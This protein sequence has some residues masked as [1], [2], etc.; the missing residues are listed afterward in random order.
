MSASNIVARKVVF[1]EREA[2][3]QEFDMPELKSH[4]IL[5]KTHCSLISVG[6]ETTALTGRWDDPDFRANPGY[7]LAG[8][9]IE[10]GNHVKDFEAGDRVFSLKNH[11][12]YAPYAQQSPGLPSRSL[13][14]FPMNRPL[15]PRLAASRS[16]GSEGPVSRWGRTLSLSEWV[17]SD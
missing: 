7:A 1:V 14:A 9:V 13:M 8:D 2:R 12:N 6:T 4:E 10:V 5:V 11:S 3:I 17:L 15:S 16:T